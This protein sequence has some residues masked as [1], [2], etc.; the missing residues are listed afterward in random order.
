MQKN[1]EGGTVVIHNW[2]KKVGLASLSRSSLCGGAVC[3][4]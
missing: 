1:K 2:I 4:L 3:I